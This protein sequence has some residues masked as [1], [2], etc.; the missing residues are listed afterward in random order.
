MHV[1]LSSLSINILALAVPIMSLQIYDRILPNPGTGTLSIFIGGV[2]L[3]IALET[4]LRLARAYTLSWTGAAY[5]HR[6]AMRAMDHVLGSN[7]ASLTRT[8]IGEYL[9]S[10]SAIGKTKDFH[11]GYSLTVYVDL[12][13]VLV[14][15]ALIGMVAGPLML[16]PGVVLMFFCVVSLYQGQNLRHH[17]QG[18]EKVDDKRYNF[19]IETLEGIGTVKSFALENNFVRRYESVQDEESRANYRVTQAM[20]LT[21]NTVFVFAG[22]MLLCVTCAGAA[23]VQNGWMTTGALIASV[24]LSGRM[25]HPIQKAMAL[26]ARYQDYSLAKQ[27]VD[28]I[29]D[30]ETH[31]V[32]E[33]RQDPIHRNGRI[34][35][36]NVSFMRQGGA[37]VLLDNVSFSIQKGECV[38]IDADRD[39]CRTAVLELMAGVYPVHTGQI[40]VDEVNI[41]QYS[42]EQLI[43]HLGYMPTEAVIF[44]GTIRDNILVSMCLK[45]P[46]RAK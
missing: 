22:V 26:W 40:K 10:V 8:G 30:V 2:I 4:I 28:H 11:N 32:M 15:L 6:L 35:L 45:R 41:G 36:E 12:L 38:L 29:F 5:E 16:V 14:Y 19:L 13:F 1:V 17:L 42:P 7:I 24:I 31:P 18:R 39:E 37:D 34:S 3:A 23:M 25:M 33:I 43:R 46:K 20:S 44:R 9:Q 27:K 21:F